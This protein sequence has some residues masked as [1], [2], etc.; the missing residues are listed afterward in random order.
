[1]AIPMNAVVKSAGHP[2]L[3][4]KRLWGF[5]KVRYRGLKKNAKGLQEGDGRRCDVHASGVLIGGAKVDS[6]PCSSGQ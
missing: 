2:L 4:L 1:M 3:I 6:S 5:A